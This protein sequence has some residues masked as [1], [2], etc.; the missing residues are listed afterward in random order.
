MLNLD[1]AHPDIYKEF[2]N[3]NFAVHQSLKNNFG[4]LEPDKVIKITINKD[5]KIP[6]GT[7]G[8]SNN[9]LSSL[10]ANSI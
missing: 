4:K 3:G 10:I 5:I 7:T 8:T 2:L 6:G 1:T 9:G